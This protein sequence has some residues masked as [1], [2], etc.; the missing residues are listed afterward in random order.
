M[1]HLLFSV[2]LFCCCLHISAQD[3]AR[4]SKLT[5]HVQKY[6]D[7]DTLDGL[8]FQFVC[9]NQDSTFMKIFVSDDDSS[10]V[11]WGN[12]IRPHFANVSD[13]KDVLTSVSRILT[14]KFTQA[15]I[16]CCSNCPV[17]S[18]GYFIQRNDDGKVLYSAAIDM[19]FVAKDFCGTER[20]NAVAKMVKELCEK[21]VKEGR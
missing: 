5:F 16:S 8:T 18:C 6:P 15:V 14:Q 9:N 1:R 4:K 21:Y 17:T 2:L 7:T 10:Y 13:D 12:M 3:T 11:F 20:L 19:Q